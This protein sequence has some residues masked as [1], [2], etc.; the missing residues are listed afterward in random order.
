MQ[1]RDSGQFENKAFNFLVKQCRVIIYKS[2]RNRFSELLST[3][4]TLTSDGQAHIVYPL[5]C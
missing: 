5:N 4:L 1:A 3:Q 2:D